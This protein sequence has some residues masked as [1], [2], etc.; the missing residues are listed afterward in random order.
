MQRNDKPLDRSA[1][2]TATWD[3]PKIVSQAVSGKLRVPTFQRSFVWDPKDVLALFDS[4]YRGFPIGTL[5]LWKQPMKTAVSRFG[6]VE[7]EVSPEPE[8]Y[9]IVDGQQR[10]TSLVASL[11]PSYHRQDE[12]F[13]VYFDLARRRFIGPLRGMRPPRSIPVREVLESRRLL[14]WLRE[15]GDDLD[16]TDLE[17][18]D[19]LGGAL[20][21]YRIPAYIVEEDDE[22]LL[23]EVFDRV[24]SAGKPISRAQVFHALFAQNTEQGSPATVVEELNARGFG[25]LDEGK[26]V[27]SLLAI[28]GGDVQRDIH[29]EFEDG[30]DIADWYDRT[31]RTL[32][33]VLSFL[34]EQGAPH[35]LLLPSTFPIPVLAAFFD[36]HPDPEDWIKEL[37][38]RWLWRGWGHGFGREAGQ[39]PALRKSIQLVNPK[40]GKPELAPDAFTAA[41]RLLETVTDVQLNTL[42]LDKFMTGRGNTRLVLLALASLAPL[43]P[44]GQEIDLPKVLESKGSAAIGQLVS[45]LRSAGANR[46]FWL[47]EWSRPTG[48]EQ[49]HILASHAISPYAASHLRNGDI[50]Q[51]LAQRH[52]DLLQ[53]TLDFVNSKMDSGLPIRPPLSSLF[54]GDPY[55]GD[56]DVR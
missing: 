40:K 43:T 36:L 34:T 7:F 9:W 41:K 46:A 32:S 3:I 50:D 21:D 6:P 54:V 24:N 39:T 14:S 42:N 49:A 4:I 48:H 30:E 29:D 38:G 17:T 53:L 35:L 2:S 25:R 13:D 1:S 31:E 44:S 56:L 23:R 47:P 18:A 5:L 52:E 10:V 20:R 33:R 19:S 51:F 11:V 37:L 27:Q 22:S 55:P 28:R 12:R 16:E 8:G 45:G 26:I 15:H